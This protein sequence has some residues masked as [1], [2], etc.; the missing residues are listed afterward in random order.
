MSTK[1][2]TGN[3]ANS[4]NVSRNGTPDSPRLTPKPQ[5][6]SQRNDSQNSYDAL[7]SKR[8]VIETAANL[9]KYT[10]KVTEKS[11]PVGTSEAKGDSKTLPKRKDN[12]S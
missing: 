3:T 10:A 1:Q 4:S 6:N 8:N 12:Q 5:E 11:K 2:N 9:A 7:E